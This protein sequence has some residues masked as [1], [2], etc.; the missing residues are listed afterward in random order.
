MI[1]LARE[2][3]HSCR[4][5]DHLAYAHLQKLWETVKSGLGKVQMITMNL[6][7]LKNIT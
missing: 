4:G 2:K 1:A 7:V 6:E 5:H 3:S